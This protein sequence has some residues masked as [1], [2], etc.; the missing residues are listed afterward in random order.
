MLL[1]G[2]VSIARGP[3]SIDWESKLSQRVVIVRD[4]TFADKLFLFNFVH[5]IATLRDI[6]EVRNAA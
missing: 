6:K 3:H 5:T 2:T 1:R 4:S